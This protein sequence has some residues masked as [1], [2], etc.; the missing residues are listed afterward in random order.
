MNHSVDETEAPAQQPQE[1][2]FVEAG[3]QDPAT[4][5][6]AEVEKWKDLAVRTAAELDNFRKRS[7][8]DMQEARSYANADLL[9]GL[10]PVLDT[11]E[12]GLEAARIESEQSIVFQGLKMVQGMFANLLKEFGV[13]EVPAQGKPFDPNLHEA[14][15]QEASDTVPDGTIL[16]VQRRGY[17]LK[18]RLLRPANV[19]VSSGAAD[20]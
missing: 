20:A 15:S 10:L 11:F 16:R 8:R 1:E 3:Q 2:P 7:A 4:A 5:L 12:M 17:K 9:R 13:E 14:L 6:A 19:V 18:D